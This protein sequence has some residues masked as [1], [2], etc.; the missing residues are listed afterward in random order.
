MKLPRSAVRFMFPAGS[1][2]PQLR[3]LR[4]ERE[5]DC[6]S[7]VYRQDV[8]DTND[9]PLCLDDRCCAGSLHSVGWVPAR[10]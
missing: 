10:S 4:F 2:K 7:D 6:N 9:F 5:Y 3:V 8:P 1:C